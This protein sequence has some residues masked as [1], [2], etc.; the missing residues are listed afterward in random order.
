MY[1]Q[2]EKTKKKKSRAVTNSVGRKKSRAKQGFGFVDNRPEAIQMRKLQEL[3][4]NSPQVAQLKK[5]QRMSVANSVAQKKSKVKQGFGFVDNRT[6]AIVQ[7]KIQEISNNSTQSRPAAQLQTMTDNSSSQQQQIMQKPFIMATVDGIV[8][9]LKMEGDLSSSLEADIKTGG[10]V[11]K[12]TG[13][14]SIPVKILDE[15]VELYPGQDYLNTGLSKVYMGD[16]AKIDAM[17]SKQ[18]QIM[19]GEDK[20]SI[21]EGHHRTIWKLYHGLKTDFDYV[22][23]TDDKISINYSAGAMKYA[24]APSAKLSKKKTGISKVEDD[25]NKARSMEFGY[26]Y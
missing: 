21:H 13:T 22:Q 12:N 20:A 9:R 11:F 18:V 14:K 3:A 19:W 1:V 8:Q 25:A 24:D 5:L 26:Q 17:N 23:T 10:N 16:S 4:K 7:R 15:D 2:V 6:E